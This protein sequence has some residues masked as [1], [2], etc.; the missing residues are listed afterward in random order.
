MKK[1]FTLLVT[2]SSLGL[3][4]QPFALDPAFNSTGY[5]TTT[6]GDSAGIG[7]SVLLQPDGKVIV[8]GYA[9]YGVIASEDFAIARYNT[10]GSLDNTFG[11]SGKVIT[12]VASLAT[13]KAYA[14][15]LQPDGKVI[16]AGEAGGDFGLVRY[17]SNGTL[18]NLFGSSG[19]VRESMS[20]GSD[21]I[22]AVDLLSDGSIIAGGC[23]TSQSLSTFAVAKFTSQG[24][25]DASF[26]NLGI[27][28]TP[29]GTGISCVFSLKVQSDGKIV[30]AGVSVPS[31]NRDITVVRYNTDGSLDLS[32]GAGSGYVTTAIGNS[33]EQAMS[34]NIQS[35]DKII[36]TGRSN[37][38]SNDDICI[39]RYNSDGSL[40]NSFNTSG[41]N[42][43][44][45]S[46]GSDWSYAS[47]IQSDGKILIGGHSTSGS[48]KNFAM[49]R[50][51]TDGSLDNT[52]ASNGILTSA[53]SSL[54]D[55]IYGIL[56][57]PDGKIVSAGYAKVSSSNRFAVARYSVNTVDVSENSSTKNALQMFPNPCAEKLYIQ[58]VKQTGKITI[59][60]S[61]GIKVFE[62]PVNTSNM[63]L[64]IEA[65]SAGHYTL[66]YQ[67]DS[68]VKSFSFIKQ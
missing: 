53:I 4:A 41:Y 31:N 7:R 59:F 10:D 21:I 32:F 56:I 63:E 22:Y 11:S 58:D 43:T 35:D 28:V 18:D 61:V 66:I 68:I 6:L 16:L 50:Y 19:I 47:T 67:G 54:D 55:A 24:I 40:D 26:G 25:L 8:A 17:N 64:N 46:N 5:A 51:N 27:A 49:V 23:I 1:L 65:F 33:N 20:S 39:V 44:N 36:I 15:I 57:Q 12:E 62:E 3:V 2:C 60:S 45:I 9:K 42:T 29:L 13:D 34:V 38:G 30:A 37:N 52:F 14:S 48:Y